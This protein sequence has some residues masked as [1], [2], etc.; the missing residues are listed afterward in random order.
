VHNGYTN[1]DAWE[2]IDGFRRHAGMPRLGEIV[3]KIG[4][5]NGTVAFVDLAY[6]I[7]MELSSKPAEV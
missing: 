5:G 3:P 7:D 6:R 1:N 2:S 4:D